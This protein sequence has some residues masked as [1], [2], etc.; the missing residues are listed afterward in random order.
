MPNSNPLAALHRFGQSVWLDD[1]RRSLFTTGKFGRR[2]A[3][4]GLRVVTS[5][6]S[7][8]EKGIAGTTEYA[9]SLREIDGGTRMAPV[10]LYETLAIR[11]IRTAADLLC[12]VYQ[13]TGRADGY[14]S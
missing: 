11:D 7:I 8:F 2:N 14:A 9:G 1:L 3:G 10:E 13:A 12:P 6:P 4:D 5:S